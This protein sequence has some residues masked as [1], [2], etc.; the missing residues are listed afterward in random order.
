MLPDSS[1]T[2]L[3]VRRFLTLQESAKSSANEI[4]AT[5]DQKINELT[6][7]NH[8]LLIAKV[9]EKEELEN[10]IVRLQDKNLEQ[11]QKVRCKTTD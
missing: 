6:C 2:A 3:D 10:M 7:N 5:K 9:K 1:E 11:G 4:L 8:D